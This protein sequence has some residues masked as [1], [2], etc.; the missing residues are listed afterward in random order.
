M[1]ELT[2]RS[3]APHT[4]MRGPRFGTMVRSADTAQTG[5]AAPI[6]GT[7]ASVRVA[8]PAPWS[9]RRDTTSKA[10]PGAS[11]SAKDWAIVAAATPPAARTSAAFRDW[12]SSWRSAAFSVFNRS[13]ASAT[14]SGGRVVENGTGDAPPSRTV[15]TMASSRASSITRGDRADVIVVL[16]SS[17]TSRTRHVVVLVLDLNA[18]SSSS[19]ARLFRSP[20]TSLSSAGLRARG[21]SLFLDL[22][23]PHGSL[24]S[25]RA[26][27]LARDLSPQMSLS[28]SRLLSARLF[29]RLV[30]PHVAVVVAALGAALAPDAAVVVAALGAA[31]EDVAVVVAALGAAL[32]DV[33]VVVPAL[34]AAL[35]DV[36]VVVAALGAAP[37]AAEDVLVVQVLGLAQAGEHDVVLVVV[38]RWTSAAPGLVAGPGLLVVRVVLAAPGLLHV[39]AELLIIVRVVRGAA[40][41]L[42]R[43]AF[44]RSVSSRRPAS[45]LRALRAARAARALFAAPPSRFRAAGSARLASRSRSARTLSVSFRTSRAPRIWPARASWFSWP[46]SR[47]SSICCRRSGRGCGC[48]HHCSCRRGP[49]ASC[50]RAPCRRAEL[51]LYRARPSET[52]WRA[53]APVLAS[54]APMNER[55]C[56][57]NWVSAAQTTCTVH[58]VAGR[59]RSNERAC[60]RNRSLAAALWPAPLRFAHRALHGTTPP[61]PRL[62]RRSTSAATAMRSGGRMAFAPNTRTTLHSGSRKIAECTSHEQARVAQSRVL[63]ALSH[64]KRT[65]RSLR[66]RHGISATVQGPLQEG[67]CTKSDSATPDAVDTFLQKMTLLDHARADERGAAQEAHE[68]DAKQGLLVQPKPPAAPAPTK[69]TFAAAL[70]PFYRDTV[71][72][73]LRDDCPSLDVGG[74]VVGDA[75]TTATLVVQELRC[76]GGAALL[77]RQIFE[78]LGCSV[79]WNVEEGTC[80]MCRRAR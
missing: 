45:P 9:S 71:A 75:E 72:A 16:P 65:A 54:A 13:K 67:L 66:A 58:T 61:F 33:A 5:A 74:L 43:R 24:S 57:R 51:Y 44:S 53:S 78:E 3:C 35:E 31:L 39:A 60:P 12:A 18:S 55:A 47:A 21:L 36:A 68:K 70:P 1:A 48:C 14:S 8:G 73:W 25:S 29:L 22:S 63:T 7:S 15:F 10:R 46:R 80:W 30:A 11:P 76:P 27:L 19:C 6:I 77:R 41:A 23:P 28:S 34:G 2:A 40:P 62:A 50:A 26:R 49:A 4:L 59:W 69:V 32:E 42:R 20:Q 37:A 38:A 79:A 17:S 56:A 64:S 52:C